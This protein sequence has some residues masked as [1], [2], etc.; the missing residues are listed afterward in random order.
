MYAYDR[1]R[2]I[3]AELEGQDPPRLI[4]LRVD[5]RDKTRARG[6]VQASGG[7]V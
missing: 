3:N 2:V 4:K 6:K 7:R 1:E 5:V